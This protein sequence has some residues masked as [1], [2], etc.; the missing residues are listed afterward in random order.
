MRAGIASSRLSIGEASGE[1]AKGVLE[2]DALQL[3]CDGAELNAI[4]ASEVQNGRDF[5]AKDVFEFGSGLADSEQIFGYLN[6]SNLADLATGFVDV[7]KGSSTK[8]W[9]PKFGE[10]AESMQPGTSYSP[11]CKRPILMV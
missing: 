10:R 7:S 8:T 3:G 6:E 5:F 11:L 4:S 1:D 9:T 2:P